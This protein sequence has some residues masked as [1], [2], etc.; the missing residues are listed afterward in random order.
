MSYIFVKDIKEHLGQEVTLKGWVRNIRHSGK[1]LFIIFRDGTGDIQSVAF[2]PELGEEAFEAAKKL[3]L[4]SSVI[5]HGIP[6]AHQKLENQ[7]ELA[8]QSLE[9]VQYAEDYPI[10]KKEHGP[11]FLLS[12]RHLW[13]RS[14]K[15]WAVLRIRHTVYHA[16]CEYLNNN[17]FIRFDS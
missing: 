17:A 12:N 2:K 7:F 13:L 1:L 15:Q 3:T 14:S 6:K 11:D 9:V 5:L 4:E 10:S 16:I 8:I